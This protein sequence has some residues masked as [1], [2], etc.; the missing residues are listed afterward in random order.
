[1]NVKK[2]NYS[3]FDYD[4]KGGLAS[5]IVDGKE[6]TKGRVDKTQ[7]GDNVFEDLKDYKFTSF[8]ANVT[9]SIPE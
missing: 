7:A 3:F 1:M 6:V 2:H 8:G 5:L 9:N 4:G